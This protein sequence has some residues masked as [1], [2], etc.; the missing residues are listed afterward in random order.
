MKYLEIGAL[1]L[2]VAV[3]FVKGVV[4]LSIIVNSFP[5]KKHKILKYKYTNF[6]FLISTATR[7]KRTKEIFFVNTRVVLRNMRSSGPG[8]GTT[9]LQYDP[10][11]FAR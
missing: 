3:R 11:S 6:P 2:P 1:C 5:Y 4:M 10:I 7:S 9:H 8:N